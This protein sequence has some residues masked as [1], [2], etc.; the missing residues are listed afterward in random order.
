MSNQSFTGVNEELV[1]AQAELE[2]S[3]RQ[4]QSVEAEE[5][6]AKINLI[7]AESARKKARLELKLCEARMKAI[8]E[9]GDNLRKEA[10]LR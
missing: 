1:Q 6:L 3:I 5:E 2:H 4:T 9:R 7:K 8:C 10:G